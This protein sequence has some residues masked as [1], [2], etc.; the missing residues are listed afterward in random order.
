MHPPMLWTRHSVADED[1]D[2]DASHFRSARSADAYWRSL[3]GA[4]GPPRPRRVAL[5]LGAY[6]SS[7]SLQSVATIECLCSMEHDA[8]DSRARP[9]PPV[10]KY[11]CFLDDDYAASSPSSCRCRCDTL[12]RAVHHLLRLRPAS[13]P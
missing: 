12:S 5:E 13:D 2:D 1:P 11:G 10:A 9:L 3:N 8:Y 7:P 6:R 4:R